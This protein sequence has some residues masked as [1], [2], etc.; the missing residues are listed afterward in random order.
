MTDVPHLVFGN[1]KQYVGMCTLQEEKKCTDFKVI[2]NAQSVI[3]LDVDVKN[4]I[5]Y[6]TDSVK[7]AIMKSAIKPNGDLLW[8]KTVID[9]YVYTPEGLAFD[10]VTNKIYW[11]DS[12]LKKIEV[13]DTDGTYRYT[14]VSTKLQK[15]RSIALHPKSG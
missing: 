2:A 6:W 8:T 3:G 9:T 14:L 12:Y 11:I 13:V 15:P 5:V 7:N 4:S 1:R 10:W